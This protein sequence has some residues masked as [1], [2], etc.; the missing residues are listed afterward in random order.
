M[1]KNIINYKEVFYYILF[2]K[3]HK[4]IDPKSIN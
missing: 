3:K 2:G 1:I 4:Y